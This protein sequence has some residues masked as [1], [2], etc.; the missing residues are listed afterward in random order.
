MPFEKFFLALKQRHPEVKRIAADE[1]IDTIRQEKESTLRL[2]FEEENGA[3]DSALL[4]EAVIPP[5]S[6]A[7]TQN[8]LKVNATSWFNIKDAQIKSFIDNLCDRLL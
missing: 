2:V 3:R 4:N 7:N 5:I 1:Y 8:Q 6:S